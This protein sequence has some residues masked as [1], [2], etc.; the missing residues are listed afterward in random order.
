VT[1]V[2]IGWVQAMMNVDHAP[3]KLRVEGRKGGWRGE[4][5]CVVVSKVGVGG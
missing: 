3:V 4:R 1:W 5:G 2:S